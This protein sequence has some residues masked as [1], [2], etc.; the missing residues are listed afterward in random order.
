MVTDGVLDALNRR[1]SASRR[2]RYGTLVLTTPE[3]RFFYDHV[4]SLVSFV[5]KGRQV[6]AEDD[7][8]RS[9]LEAVRVALKSM[10]IKLH[11]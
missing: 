11:V 1:G 8:A 7:V 4:L 3:G 9:Q 5:P 2:Q 6:A 10:G